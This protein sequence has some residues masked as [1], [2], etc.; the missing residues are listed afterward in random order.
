MELVFATF[1]VIQYRISNK[2]IDAGED[3]KRRKALA[4]GEPAGATWRYHE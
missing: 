2:R 3:S 1:N 4:N